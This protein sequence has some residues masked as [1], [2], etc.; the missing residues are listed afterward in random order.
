MDL[1]SVQACISMWQCGIESQGN[2]LGPRFKSQL[3]YFATA[4][5]TLPLSTL[6]HGPLC[7]QKEKKTIGH[8][9]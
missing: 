4:P 3:G 1:L 2:V 6:G 7:N 9:M 8:I 5:S